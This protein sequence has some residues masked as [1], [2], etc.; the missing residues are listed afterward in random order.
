MKND[1]L[2][3]VSIKFYQNIDTHLPFIHYCSHYTKADLNSYRRDG[4]LHIRFAVWQVTDKFACSQ[5]EQLLHHHPSYIFIHHAYVVL[6]SVLFPFSSS[7]HT[8]HFESGII[9]TKKSNCKWKKK[10]NL[11]SLSCLSAV[12]P[13][14]LSLCS[15]AFIQNFEGHTLYPTYFVFKVEVRS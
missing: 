1:I 6:L 11:I 14:L 15:A 7:S 13:Q 5:S 8:P 4:V 3:L 2:I 9:I 12:L 10:Y